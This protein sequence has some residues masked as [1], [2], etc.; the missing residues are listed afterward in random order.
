MKKNKQ[1]LT[2][3]ELHSVSL[4]VC[5]FPSFCLFSVNQT[6]RERERERERGGGGGGEENYKLFTTATTQK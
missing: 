3:T 5:L 1:H 2:A 6:K 4:F